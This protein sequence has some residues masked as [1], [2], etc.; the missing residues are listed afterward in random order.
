MWRS[1]KTWISLGIILGVL[2]GIPSVILL[3]NKE[4]KT[5]PSF[6]DLPGHERPEPKGD[7]DE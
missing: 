4:P 7:R 6:Y 1:I 5:I 2:I 3:F